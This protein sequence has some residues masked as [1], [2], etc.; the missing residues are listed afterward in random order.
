M[1]IWEPF[2][3]RI[4]MCKAIAALLC[5]RALDLDAFARGQSWPLPLPMPRQEELFHSTR[6]VDSKGLSEAVN[7]FPH[8]KVQFFI[9]NLRLI[10]LA[11]WLDSKASLMQSALQTLS[12]S[13]LSCCFVS[14]LCLTL[15]DP[16]DYSP[17]GSSVHGIFQAR[18]LEWVAIA[19]SNA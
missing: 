9:G 11:I 12:C 19:F 13:I 17:P 15:C 6:P 2:Y 4:S 7:S 3:F 5:P 16:V 8:K 1:C 18:V 14:Q 10:I